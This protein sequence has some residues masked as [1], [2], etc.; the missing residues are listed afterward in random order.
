MIVFCRA[1][2]NTETLVLPTHLASKWCWPAMENVSNS[3]T[4]LQTSSWSLSS[5]PSKRISR[6][7]SSCLGVRRVQIEHDLT[8]SWASKHWPIIQCRYSTIFE[9]LHV[10]AHRAKVFFKYH[11]LISCNSSFYIPTFLTLIQSFQPNFGAFPAF[12]ESQANDLCSGTSSSVNDV[13]KGSI[14]CQEIQN[15]KEHINK[16]ISA[17]RI[18]PNTNCFTG[19][20]CFTRF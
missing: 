6:S 15:W 19:V 3:F 5:Q 20:I 14:L 17:P 10:I 7:S 1:I 12:R 4:R 11:H 16:H 2:W 8:T 13:N 9:D 18:V